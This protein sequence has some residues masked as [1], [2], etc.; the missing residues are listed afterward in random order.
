MALALVLVSCAL[1]VA[2]WFLLFGPHSTPSSTSLSAQPQAERLR[3]LE[4]DVERRRREA[5]ET[6]AASNELRA[7]L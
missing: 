6:K 7:E 1:V 4:A 5:D 3:A 2:V